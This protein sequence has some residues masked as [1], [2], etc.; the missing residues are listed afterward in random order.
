MQNAQGSTDA[1]VPSLN[2]AIPAHDLRAVIG[3]VLEL[4]EVSALLDRPVRWFVSGGPNIPR[5]RNNILS[6]IHHAFPN[7]SKR[8]VLWMDSDIDI[9]PGQAKLISE[10][11]LWA[12]AHETGVVAN[13]R[14]NDGGNVLMANRDPGKTANHFSDEEIANLEKYAP[15]GMA[16]LGFVYL[17]QPLGYIFHADIIGEDIYFFWENPDVHLHYMKNVR[18]AHRKMI[19]LM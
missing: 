4:Y 14:M 9:L 12:E 6:N 16:G 3:S 7:C 2:I 17:E 19:P 8:W 13:Y 1:G 18:L 11:I 5:T 10:A 15:I